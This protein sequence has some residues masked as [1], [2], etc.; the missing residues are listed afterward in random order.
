VTGEQVAFGTDLRRE[1][2]RRDISLAS[3][4]ESTKINRSLLAALERGDA[5]QWPSGIYRRAF[6]REYALALGLSPG[7]IVT[8]FIRLF[9]EGGSKPGPIDPPEGALRLTLAHES[10]WSAVS[11]LPRAG[12]ASCDIML[13][14]LMAAACSS[15]LQT[16][17]WTVVGP[18]TV[19]YYLIAAV[20]LGTTPALWLLNTQVFDR[21]H[22]PHAG[23]QQRPSSRELLRI[24]A[25]APRGDAPQLQYDEEDGERFV[26]QARSALR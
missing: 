24:V 7:P 1:R 11:M 2:E 16:D 25:S 18:V 10:Q 14:L 17:F 22:S 20:V 12:W 6:I 26:E 4:A 21:S 8:N 19:A 13:L 3:V 5:S 23:K 15:L 9:P